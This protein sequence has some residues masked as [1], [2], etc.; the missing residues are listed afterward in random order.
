VI[1]AF[2]F[3]QTGSYVL[4]N[5]ETKEQSFPG[6]VAWLLCCSNHESAAALVLVY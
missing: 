1:C 4:N 5:K 3:F 6:L 2:F